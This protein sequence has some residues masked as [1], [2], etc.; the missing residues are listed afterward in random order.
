[1]Q[2]PRYALIVT[3]DLIFTPLAEALDQSVQGRLHKFINQEHL[4]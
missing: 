3:P 1:M 4:I 2:L